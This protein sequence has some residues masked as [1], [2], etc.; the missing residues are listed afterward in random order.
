MTGPDMAELEVNPFA[1]RRQ[2]MTP[3]DGRGRLATATLRPRP[4]PVEQIGAM[5]EP[6][7]IA[8]LGVSSKGQNFGCIDPEQHRGVG[9]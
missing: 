1:F 7:T 8:V 2:H 6:R 9:V 4:R 5:L 3:L